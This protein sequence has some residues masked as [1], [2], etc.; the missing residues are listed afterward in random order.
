MEKI[1]VETK[2]IKEEKK[3]EESESLGVKSAGEDSSDS[4]TNEINESEEEESES[5]ATKS[6]ITSSNISSGAITSTTGGTM[7]KG[8]GAL[9]K[10]YKKFTG[11]S[12]GYNRN[13]DPSV[14]AW[15][16]RIEPSRL[17]Q[18]QLDGIDGNKDEILK[19]IDEKLLN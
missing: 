6:N 7:K 10:N 3:S 17:G 15:A 5:L 11:S 1:E 16:N 14:L 19:L 2:A 4:L 12:L 13:G 9:Q 8:I 18:Q